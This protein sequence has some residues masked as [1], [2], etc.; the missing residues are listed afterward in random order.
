MRVG[1]VD[2]VDLLGLTGTE[3]FVGVEAPSALQKALAAS[4]DQFTG[5]VTA[6]IRAFKSAGSEIDI[7][8]NASPID[9]SAQ[10]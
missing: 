7:R 5:S 9:T 2:A 6:A 8:E 4:A 10:L 1:A 3:C